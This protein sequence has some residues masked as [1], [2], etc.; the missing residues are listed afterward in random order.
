MLDGRPAIAILLD[1]WYIFSESFLSGP[2]SA[3]IAAVLRQSIGE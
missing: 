1:I 2:I 3:D